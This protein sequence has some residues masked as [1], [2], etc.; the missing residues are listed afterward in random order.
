MSFSYLIFLFICS[1]G[2]SC[3]SPCLWDAY[4]LVSKCSSGT[5]GTARAA[6]WHVLRPREHRSNGKQGT[7]SAAQREVHAGEQSVS[8]VDE[9]AHY[10]AEVCG[11]LAHRDERLPEAWATK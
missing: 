6:H 5:W 8:G 1:A 9:N 4:V 11:A 3:R 7:A 10:K 2:I